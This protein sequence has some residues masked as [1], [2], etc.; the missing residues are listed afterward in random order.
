MNNIGGVPIG[1]VVLFVILGSLI[2]CTTPATPSESCLSAA[3]NVVKKSEND[4]GWP[5]SI[6]GVSVINRDPILCKG[7]A[8]L[9]DDTTDLIQFYH[10]SD[11]IGF[12]SL[13]I[14]QRQCDG[15]LMNQI[16]ALSKEKSQGTVR[17]EILKIYDPE[18]ISNTGDTLTCRGEALLD[19]NEREMI[20][21]YLEEDKD[22]DRFVGYG[23]E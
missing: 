5:I 13:P 7:T 8:T 14:D 9:I 23:T 11:Q 2:N 21:F 18:E 12:E 22:G 16:I 10:H 4:S 20:E 6:T 17:G 3:G 15:I 19:T 1:I